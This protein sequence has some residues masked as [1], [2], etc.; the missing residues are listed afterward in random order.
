[1]ET[2]NLR[3]DLAG[4]STTLNGFWRMHYWDP[5][6]QQPEDELV[7]KRSSTQRD[8][9]WAMN[10]IWLPRFGAR[11]MD[12]VK[13]AEIQKFLASLTGPKEEGKISRQTA[14]KYKTYI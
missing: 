11:N 6:K 14:L 1:M 7:T 8:V 2:I 3:R 12:S 4:D 10:N 5:E 9:R 13:T